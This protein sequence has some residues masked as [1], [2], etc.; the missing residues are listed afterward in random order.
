MDLTPAQIAEYDQTRSIY[1]NLAADILRSMD[2][3]YHNGG[4]SAE[5]AYSYILAI[6]IGYKHTDESDEVKWNK[7]AALLAATF[8]LALDIEHDRLKLIRSQEVEL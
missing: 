8:G 2:V 7:I 4:D 5:K 3:C 1:K 6:A